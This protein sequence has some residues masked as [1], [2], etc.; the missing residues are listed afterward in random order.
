V[1]LLGLLRELIFGQKKHEGTY[2]EDFIAVDEQ[3][4]DRGRRRL[5]DPRHIRVEKIQTPPSPLVKEREPVRRSRSVDSLKRYQSRTRNSSRTTRGNRR[6]QREQH[7]GRHE[8]DS[9]ESTDINDLVEQTYREY[10]SDGAPLHEEERPRRKAGHRAAHIP[11]AQVTMPLPVFNE[12]APEDSSTRFWE[13]SRNRRQERGSSEQ[14]VLPPMHSEIQEQLKH[15][16]EDE[17]IVVTERYVYRPQRVTRA[18]IEAIE[19]DGHERLSNTSRHSQK[20]ISNDDTADYYP[21]EWA[22]GPNVERQAS[23][24]RVRRDLDEVSLDTGAGS[25]AG[26]LEQHYYEGMNS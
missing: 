26:S 2:V 18:P 14:T 3:T 10:L 23:Y 7:S 19:D 5:R 8:Y 17:M 4:R 13:T 24:Q 11:E 22:R 6:S 21:D 20:Y 25:F 1:S 9:Q 12:G 15:L 16:K